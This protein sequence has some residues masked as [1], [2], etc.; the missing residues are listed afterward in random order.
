MDE[1]GLGD[2]L[3][4]LAYWFGLVVGLFFKT[5]L[6]PFELVGALIE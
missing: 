6:L 1:K 4:V 2:V 3:N 5:L